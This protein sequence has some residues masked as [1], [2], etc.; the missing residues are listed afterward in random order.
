MVSA[1]TL[2]SYPYWKIT[3]TVH[4]DASGINLGAVMSHNN[5]TIALLSRILS[6]PQCNYNTT[7]KNLLVVVECFKQ[8]FEILFGYE[9]NVFSYNKNLVYVETLS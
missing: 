8:C 2:L 6:N 4:T 7:E 1:E 5:K 9:I 3:F